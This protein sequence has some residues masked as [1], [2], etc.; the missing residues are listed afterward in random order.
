MKFLKVLIGHSSGLILSGIIFIL[1]MP[2]LSDN[3]ATKL[4]WQYQKLMCW[5]VEK[6]HY[7]LVSA[8]ML[9]DLSQTRCDKCGSLISQTD[10]ID[11]QSRLKKFS[12]YLLSFTTNSDSQELGKLK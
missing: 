1:N 7:D 9:I 4:E 3:L 5:I 8:F 6:H 2:R 11:L 10:L 12:D